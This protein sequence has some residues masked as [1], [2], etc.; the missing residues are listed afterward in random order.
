VEEI[1]VYDYESLTSPDDL[2][3]YEEDE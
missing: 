2:L 3:E 1:E